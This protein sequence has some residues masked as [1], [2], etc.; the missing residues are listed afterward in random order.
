M[1]DHLPEKEDQAASEIERGAERIQKSRSKPPSSPLL[2]LGMFGMIG[3]SITVPT[4]CGAV[5]GQWL[6]R[7]VPQQFSWTITLLFIGVIVG[8]VVAWN[9]VRREGRSE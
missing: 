7:A 6:D 5:L 2:G 1:T 3:W 4:I 8:G 9:W